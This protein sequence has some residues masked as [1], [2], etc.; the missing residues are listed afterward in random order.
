MPQPITDAHSLA[1]RVGDILVSQWVPDI[2]SIMSWYGLYNWLPLVF[3]GV[4][5]A[6]L[7]S[8][9]ASGMGLACVAFAV[10]P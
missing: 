8:Y 9:V 6:A 1:R 4:S 7:L 3:T 5:R 2:F 10:R